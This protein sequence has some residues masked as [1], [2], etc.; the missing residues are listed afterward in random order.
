MLSLFFVREISTQKGKPFL[1]TL[2]ILPDSLCTLGAIYFSSG[3]KVAFVVFFPRFRPHGVG[4]TLNLH[5]DD[6]SDGFCVFIGF[7]RESRSF[8]LLLG[9]R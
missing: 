8:G 9:C 5:F 7:L 2:E 3:P 4:F 6:F 1:R